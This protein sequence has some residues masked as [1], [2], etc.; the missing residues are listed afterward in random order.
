MGRRAVGLVSGGLDS[1]LA[2]RMVQQMG[3]EVHALHV[4]CGFET[5][6]LRSLMAGR[7]LEA[8]DAIGHSGARVELLDLRNPFL[9]VLAKPA[10][11]YGSQLNPCIDCKI[12]M[13][14]SAAERMRALRA[15]FVFTGEVLGQRP[16]SQRKNA[17]DV[18]ARESGLENH[19]VRPLCGGKLPPSA[20]EQEGLIRRDQL[21]SIQGRS[22]KP[23]IQLAR[24][25]G[26]DDY[27]APAGGCLLT[28][29][30]Y[31]ARVRRWLESRPGRRLQREDPLLLFVGRH[32]VL[33]SGAMVVVGRNQ[34]ENP[35]IER[36]ARYG[37]L[38]EAT[39]VAGPTTLLVRPGARPAAGDELL[40][41]RL[42]ARYGQG[43]ANERV[44]VCIR[45]PAGDEERIEVA[46]GD[47]EESTI[48]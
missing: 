9:D 47:V 15:S 44:R 3:F 4:V 45:R 42:T 11:G 10:H 29:P 24:S 37:P 22:R 13:L 33:P 35:V 46:P 28:D 12:L 41:A 21:A 20:P 25:L 16:M 7:P 8:P 5:A 27:P 19:L 43:R 31:A 39:D 40:A 14:Q 17:L 32:L 38:L 6:H 26:I 30:A 23:Q 18:V 36:Y 2:V 1:L 48:L 34:E